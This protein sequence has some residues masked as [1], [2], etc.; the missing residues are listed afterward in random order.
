[1]N[2]ENI[3]EEKFIARS[4]ENIDGAKTNNMTNNTRY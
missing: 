3:S 2:D 1:M 4:E